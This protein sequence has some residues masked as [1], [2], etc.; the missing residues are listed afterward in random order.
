MYKDMKIKKQM[1]L[2]AV[3]L[4]VIPVVIWYVTSYYYLQNQIE[5]SQKNYL[6][7]A[8]NVARGEIQNRKSEML[9]VAN[10][11]S[12]SGKLSESVRQNELDYVRTMVGNLQSSCAYLDFIIV[13][14]INKNILVRSNT[15]ILNELNPKFSALLDA[16]FYL[17]SGIT[18][19]EALDLENI[20][21]NNTPH[22]NKFVV[23]TGTERSDVFTKASIG[24]ALAPILDE[25]GE[26]VGALIMGD[27]ANNDEYFPNYYT[28]VLGESFLAISI[29]GIRVTSNIKSGISTDYIGTK[30]PVD[31]KSVD[32]Q[33]HFGK[34]KIGDEV[35]IY[36]DEEI[37][38]YFGKTI[39]LIGVGVPEEIFID[40]LTTN[41]LN[42]AIFAIIS[43]VLV[44]FIADIMA[45][46]I[47]R[48]ILLTTSLA[49]R[50]THGYDNI[51]MDS[52]YNR[53][54]IHGAE[55]KVLVET[56]KT[57]LEQ[58]KKKQVDIDHY[59]LQLEDLNNEL[60]TKV[61]FR[62]TALRGAMLEVTRAD[63]IKSEFLA[64]MSH[65]LRTPLSVIISSVDV[66]S[67][68]AL[69]SLNAKQL[70]YAHNI[71]TSANNLLQLINDVLDLSK[72]NAGK[73][74]I[75]YSLFYMRDFARQMVEQM[76]SL[77]KDKPIKMYLEPGEEDFLIS[78]DISKMKQIFYNVL[79]NAIKFT[80]R[81]EVSVRVLRRDAVCE[82]HV[83]DT[84]IG[85]S[86]ENLEK[87]FVEFVQLDNVYHKKHEGTGLGLALIKKLITMQ[88]GNIFVKSKLGE[89]TE[90]LF[91]IPLRSDP[92]GGEGND[93]N[94]G[95]G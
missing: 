9:K 44:L 56:F 51:D 26:M 75:N 64:N 4:V 32:G 83:K 2:F 5:K 34:A 16:A 86:N 90:V 67:Q 92:K 8:I 22:Y 43:L 23:R 65:E 49:E 6:N 7:V 20:Y 15:D 33:A 36:L 88:G 95:G 91:T 40:M 89:G 80:E 30:A 61:E 66:L 38:D 76:Q 63:K 37:K 42:L 81:G 73:M 18:S 70:K 3:V 27:I 54:S 59:I 50:I 39:G 53:K 78:A 87:I 94:T 21:Y 77:I 24:M 60:E 46:N 35:H 82:V 93:Q 28:S 41:Y 25:R 31:L 68:Q 12:K 55:S 10:F 14:D 19:E 72:I 1:S 29:D 45:D 85:I 71:F 69:G 74:D 17:K 13:V 48:P 47:T 52:E 84:G 62:T 57:L 58:L 79:S 11:L